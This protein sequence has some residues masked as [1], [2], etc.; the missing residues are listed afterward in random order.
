MSERISIVM[1][2]FNAAAWLEQ[3]VASVQTQTH[4]DWELIAVDDCSSDGSFCML[5]KMAEKDGR[6]RP[7]RL[8]ENIGAAR[9]RNEGIRL[10][11]GRYLAFLD[12]DDLWKKTKLEKELAFLKERQAAFAFTA[13]E[14]GD[15][16]GIGNGKI[17][18]VP[19]TLSYK[20]ALSRTI[21]FTTTVMFDLEKIDR[22]LIFMPDVKSEDTATWWRILR[23]GYTACG[24]NENLAVYR[25]PKNSLSSNKLEAVRRI[26]NLYRKQEG[27][28][29]PV[30]AYYLFFWALRATVRRL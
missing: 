27:L 5:Q 21:I 15:E 30:S 29:A 24:L 20:E 7:V 13:Y 26:W 22:S 10:A 2:V 3:T 4:Q 17:V 28:S 8:E 25:R 1:P 14:F 6:I 12:S 19:Q 23:A 18:R 16:N 11:R 9:T